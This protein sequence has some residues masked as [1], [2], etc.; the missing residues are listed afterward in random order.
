M[1]YDPLTGI[2]LVFEPESDERWIRVTRQQRDYLYQDC[3]FTIVAQQIVQ[4]WDAAP[5]R[6]RLVANLR[7]ALREYA[8]GLRWDEAEA[9]LDALHD[10]GEAAS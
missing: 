4:D 3:P 5:T 10:S 2:D 7:E 6:N 1:T 9:I 8:P